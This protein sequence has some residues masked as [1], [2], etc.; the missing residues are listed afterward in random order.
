MDNNSVSAYLCAL[1]DKTGLSVRALS[2]QTG[3]PENTINNIL[4]GRT[5]S[6]SFDV[7]AAL[8]RVMGGSTDE[9]AGIPRPTPPDPVPPPAPAPKENSPAHDPVAEL[10]EAY[11]HERASFERG[12]RHRN[13]MILVLLVLMLLF[14]SWLVWDITH[15]EI[16]LIRYK[17]LSGL[18]GL[19]REVY[20][21]A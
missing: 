2:D 10:K 5:A 4:Y 1:R 7:V 3:V 19:W 6:P 11:A 12:L 14:L 13:I 20:C 16:G 18:F 8:V 17:E 21:H 9:L 15:P